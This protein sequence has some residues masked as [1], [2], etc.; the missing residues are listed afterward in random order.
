MKVESEGAKRVLITEDVW[1][2]ALLMKQILE[3]AGFVA[4]TALDGQEC[5]EKI[6]VF[7]PDLVIMDIMM[8]KVHGLE[9]CGT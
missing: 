7:K 2:I 4:E 5:L 8:P 3:K 1:S 6:P 9:A